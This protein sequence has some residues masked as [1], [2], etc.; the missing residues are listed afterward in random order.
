MHTIDENQ[1]GIIRLLDHK[2]NK[3]TMEALEKKV[4]S[5][6]LNSKK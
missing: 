3:A 4:V 1:K 5:E 6:R 2:R